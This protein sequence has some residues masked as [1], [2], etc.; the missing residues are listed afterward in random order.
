M[1]TDELR[2]IICLDFKMRWIHIALRLVV[3]SDKVTVKP[4]LILMKVL[5]VAMV[6]FGLVFSFDF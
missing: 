3:N 6:T 5:S 1:R 2:F 4:T